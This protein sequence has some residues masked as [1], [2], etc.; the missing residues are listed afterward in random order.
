TAGRIGGL[1]LLFLT[2]ELK[3]PFRSGGHA[4][5]HVGHLRKLLMRFHDVDS[6]SIT[7]NGH[8]VRDFDRTALREGFGMVLQD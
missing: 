8:N 4:L 7:L 2:Q 3:H 1:V 6:G 5:Q